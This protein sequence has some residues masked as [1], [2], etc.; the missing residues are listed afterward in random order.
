MLRNTKIRLPILALMLI[1]YL[2]GS[3]NAAETT[4]VINELMASNSTTNQD[5]QGQYDDWIEIHNYGLDAIDIGGMYLTD[6][7]SAPAKWRIPSS[8]SALTTIPAGGYL[9]I[10]ADNDT[11]AAGL[12]ANFKLDAAGEEIGLFDSD[13]AT[14]IDSVT[15]G[16]Q[17]DD[18]SYGRYPDAADYWQAFGSPSP[19]AQ[20]V[21]VYEGFVSDIEFSHKR[22][23]YNESFYLTLATETEDAIIYYS[24]DGSDPF[25]PT[26][27]GSSSGTTYT[28][29]IQI[30]RTTIL[31]AI[32]TK[33]GWMSTDT[34]TQTYIFVEDVIRQSPTG[35]APGPGWPS[36]SVNGQTINYGMDPDVVND[37][38]YKDLMDD[39]LLAIPS[40]SLV[41]DLDNLFDPSKGIYVNARMLGRTWERPVSVELINPD[42]S[43]GFQ[44]DAGLRIR[45]GYSRQDSNPKHAFRLFFRAE[46]GQAKL[47]FPL[48]EDEGVSEFDNVDLRTSQNY[49]WSYDGSS[50]N[51]MV[52][53]VFSRDT[54]RDMGQPY[55][56]SRYYHLYL[57]GQYWGIFQTQE[58][59]EASYAESYFGGTRDDYD[60]IK[61]TGGNPNYTIEATDGTIDAYYRLWQA[62]TNGFYTD[63]AYYKVQGMNPDGTRNPAYERLLD[64]DNLIDYMLCTFYVGDCDGPI[65][66]FL[67]N[68]RPNNYYGIYNRINPDGFKFFRHDGEHTI[69]AQGS[70]NLD[71]TGPYSAGQQFADFNPQWLHQRLAVHPEYRLRMGDRAHKYFFNDG[72]LTPGQSTWRLM[73]RAEQI[74][75]AIIAESA[76][77]GDSRSSRPY[78]KDDHWW[79]E[80]NRIINDYD[81]YGFPLRTQVVLGQLQSKDWYPNVDAPV[82]NING[83]Y[84]HGGEISADDLL[85]MTARTGTILYTL[86]GSDPR[87]SGASQQ[88]DALVPEDA[89]KRAIVP[90]GPVG[91]EWKG[92]GDFDDST[93]LSCT[94]APGGVGFERTTGFEDFIS[95]DLQE[96]MY[97]RNATCYVRIPFTVDADYTSLTLNVRYDDGFVAYINGVE[98]ARRN[99]DGTPAWNSSA[100]ASHA[101]S[102]AVLFESIDI[103]EFI[104]KLQQDDNLLAIQAMNSSTTSSDFLIS[105]E[106]LGSRDDS[107][108]SDQGG[109]LEYTGPITL[110]HSVQVKARVLSGETWSALN[111]T[112]YAIG[113]VAENL[114]ITEIMYNPPDP[115][116]EFV[117]LQNIGSETI[118]LNLVSFINGI[119]FTFP[120]IELAAGE[121]TVVVQDRNV[122][123]ARYGTNIN[124]AG[125][126]SGKL[127]NAGERIELQDAIGRMIL[128]FR[129]E[130]GWRSITDGDGFSLTIID[131][132][133]PDPNSW[134]EKD[135]W[136]PSAYE[137]GSPDSDDS[138]I[139]P[140]P[141]AVVI[142]EV[143]AHAHAEASDWIELHNTTET[144][145][146]IGGWFLSDS[147][148]DIF[149]YKIPN[150]TTIGPNGYLVLYEDLNFGNENDPACY[151]PFALSENGEQLY[152]SSTK[153]S[154]LTGYR[155]TEDF[156]SSETGVSFGR[157][158]IPSTGNYNFAAMEENTPGSANSYPKVGPIVINEIMY[159]PDWPHGG[160]YTND[161]YEYIE[162][163]NI[164]AEPVS[165]YDY[166]VGEPWKFTG[167]IDF[168]FPT[169]APV[170]IPAGGV[171]LV[172]NHPAAFSRRYPAVPADIILGPYEGN[173]SNAGESLELSMPGDLD[174]E[175]VRQYI[176][177]DRIN[178]SDG[179][180]PENCP[181]GIDLW[182]VEA[183]GDGMA[184][185]RTVLT[186]YGNDPDNWLAAPPSPGQ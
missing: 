87:S 102:A 28:N 14:E 133:N 57:N 32:A 77:W 50:K 64:V 79:P 129:Y 113:P 148:K 58:R 162:L 66:N 30:N 63:E 103:S 180:N 91:N 186:D 21:G 166:G 181:G 143:M 119:D 2:I 172:V 48:F 136:R 34:K 36:G 173:L 126:Y 100:S 127:D 161:Q 17:A 65:S 116:E 114:R 74:E 35:Q 82:F 183:D 23:F 111:E 104:D 168:T 22:G 137:G 132:M 51:T 95:I 56:R 105:A 163:H 158:F 24:L 31:K 97:A 99:F 167:G 84:Q 61:T 80:I 72:L 68:S 38:R 86:D 164:S 130:N 62:A 15:F 54:Q 124:I 93:W 185:T 144:A 101:D 76:R 118:N 149:K 60:V 27:R 147:K 139:I 108:D 16:E 70:W 1:T 135:S 156:G 9:L 29:P 71:R 88:A 107:D 153:N 174:K 44:I 182:P 46:Y 112:V 140:N 96:Q 92:G 20:N 12:H 69:G 94:G 121:Y 10:W 134:G 39:A 177:A 157:Y 169:Y 151:E 176:R 81:A 7:L 73:E 41:T 83:A 165:L 141:G 53:E 159:N 33:T 106:I 42:G 138:G 150:G 184:L 26:A 170:T 131:A 11:T 171:L 145:I 146:D 178:Y 67:G 43:E 47:S 8:N 128:N 45:G 90:V 13:G 154:V 25:Q 160:S 125:Q 98:V 152:L 49:S 4:L 18:I 109:V 110:P 52:R 155:T 75:M 55:T 117:E 142:N 122:F 37:S 85:S 59:S 120:N 175:N 115:N 40:I 179:S 19:A 89:D 6:S 123:E 5:P 3:A 78:T